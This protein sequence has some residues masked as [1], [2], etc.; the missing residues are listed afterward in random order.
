VEP[1]WTTA[2]IDVPAATHPATLQFWQQVTGYDAS[3]PRGEHD[4]LLSLVPPDGDPHLK[5]QRLDGRPASPRIHLDLHV[6]DPHAAAERAAALGAR[7]VADRGHVVMASPGGFPFCLV[8]HSASRPTAAVDWADGAP[9]IV[10]QVCLDVPAG[11]YDA[12]AG[13]WQQLTGWE[14][15]ASPGHDEFDRLRRPVGQPLHLL[16][17]RLDESEGPVRAHLDLAC[18]DRER[19]ARRHVRLGAVRV[20]DHDDWTVLHDP[21]GAPYCITD[22][23]PE[24]DVRAPETGR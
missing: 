13:F 14:R 11:G 2:F 18:A 9:S 8:R 7:E 17:Q 20:A 12:E 16:L 1:F 23:P 15:E 24:N 22:R 5:V 6:T 10:D 21:A 3:E 19:E 4:E